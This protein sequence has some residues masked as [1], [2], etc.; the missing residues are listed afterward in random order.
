MV[1]MGFR[2]EMTVANYNYLLFVSCFKY[3]KDRCD[4][5]VMYLFHAMN[6]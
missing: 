4:L 2:L 3:V 5:P 6:R 1:V